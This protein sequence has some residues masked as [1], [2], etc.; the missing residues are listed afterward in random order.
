MDRFI[1]L[2][3]EE[4]VKSFTDRGETVPPFLCLQPYVEVHGVPGYIVPGE[5]DEKIAKRM[6]DKYRDYVAV[7]AIDKGFA[8]DAYPDWLDKKHEL[9]PIQKEFLD[10]KRKDCGVEMHIGIPC[11]ELEQ[12]QKDKDLQDDLGQ[13]EALIRGD[14]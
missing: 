11:I 1:F 13:Q 7:N 4:Y 9:T 2:P 12:I 10:Q 14:A 6:W 8:F 5:S 3:Q